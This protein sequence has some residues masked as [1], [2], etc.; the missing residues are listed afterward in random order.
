MR[1]GSDLIGW[2][3]ATGVWY[4]EQVPIAVRIGLTANG[5]AEVA[6]ATSDIGTGTYTTMAQTAMQDVENK[7]ALLHAQFPASAPRLRLDTAHHGPG[8]PQI[9]LCGI[10]GRLLHG[11]CVLKWLLVQLDKNNL[12]CGRYTSTR[13]RET[14][15]TDASRQRTIT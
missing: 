10:D 5:H 11:D 12:P 8:R 4:A 14:W 1:D 15:P 2:G 13:T 3:M 7:I 6:C 9:R